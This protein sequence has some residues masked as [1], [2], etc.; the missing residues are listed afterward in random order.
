MNTNRTHANRP[1]R[2]TQADRERMAQAVAQGDK[3]R[4]DARAR[5]RLARLAV[6]CIALAV[7]VSL[8]YSATN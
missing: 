7:V 1:S 3:R 4:R 5:E 2:L 6:A 8:F